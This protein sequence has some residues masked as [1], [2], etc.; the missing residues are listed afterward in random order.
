MRPPCE[1]IV[2]YILPA[3]RSMIAKE[4]KEKYHLTQTAAAE[5]LGTTQAAISYYLYSKRGKKHIVQLEAVPGV[6]EA[7][8]KV[9]KEIVEEGLSPIDAITMFCKLCME[10]RTEDLVCKIHKD[11]VLLPEA[12]KGCLNILNVS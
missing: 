7:A 3:F 12:C 5:K 4:L 6:R 9:T 8:S 1:V 10:L 11:T 2:R